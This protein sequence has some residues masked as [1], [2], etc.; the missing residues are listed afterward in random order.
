MA[1][2]ARIWL[3]MLFASYLIK[4]VISESKPK[5]TYEKEKTAI[6]KKGNN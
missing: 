6:S 4:A 2:L 1:R 5:D 3:T